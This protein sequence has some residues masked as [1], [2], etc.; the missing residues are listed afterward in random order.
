[1]IDAPLAEVLIGW[2]GHGEEILSDTS[3]EVPPVG[4][5]KQRI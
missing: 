5:G 1:M 2:L 3:A 4:Q